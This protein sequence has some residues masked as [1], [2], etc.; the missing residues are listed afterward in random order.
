[1]T[2]QTPRGTCAVCGRSIRLL[3]RGVI[4]PHND[5]APFVWPP[6]RCSGWS[7]PPKDAA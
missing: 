3:K 4:G 6:R 5:L 2:D 1:M 7:Q